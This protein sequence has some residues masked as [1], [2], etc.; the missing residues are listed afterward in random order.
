MKK[1]PLALSRNLQ[2]FFI[3]IFIALSC[4]GVLAQRAT[5]TPT[6]APGIRPIRPI[7]VKTPVLIGEQPPSVTVVMPADCKNYLGRAMQSLCESKESYDVCLSYL[8][9]GKWDFCALAG[10]EKM[11]ARR[12]TREEAEARLLK[13]NCTEAKLGRALI[14]Q[15]PSTDYNGSSANWECI[16]YQN[17]TPGIGCAPP[18]DLLGIYADKIMQALKGKPVGLAFVVTNKKG[19]TAERAWG[20]ARKSPDS[21]PMKMTTDSKYSL[22]SVSKNIT[23]AALMH[24][25]N[26]KGVKVTDR[27]A[28]YLP[29]DFLP[30]MHISFIGIT[31]EELLTHRAG[32]RCD[33]T[34]NVDYESLKKCTAIGVKIDDKSKDC[35]G[36]NLGNTTD[37]GCYQNT[38]Y[39]LMRLLIPGLNGFDGY[40]IKDPAE[41]AAKFAQLYSDYVNAVDF[42]KAGFKAYCHPTD[43]DKQP[44]AYK[45]SAPNGIGGDFGNN[46]L[47]CGSMGWVLSAKMLSKYFY[48]LNFS[49]DIVTKKVSEQ[50]RE[51]LYGYQAKS[52]FDSKFGKVRM[53]WHGGY[54][55]GSMN[56]GEINTIV[57][58]F[59]NGIQIAFIMNSDTPSSVNFGGVLTQS[60]IDAMNLQ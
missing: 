37:I 28:D 29:A 24:L 49:E 43:G 8:K 56:P 9:Q 38:D 19:E 32:I 52:E 40:K 44:L 2:I 34:L 30:G 7:L 25:L 11:V 41:K 50:M 4:I 3:T 12:S 58:N 27:M 45:L 54:H 16:A 5:P 48:K 20:V 18:L 36:N 10:S 39:A 33:K 60:M 57:I 53:Y 42:S 6:P 22:A 59:S 31:F 15:C 55:P 35:N 13:L 47:A 23:A 26:S 17:G 51:K 14:F 46:D 21:N 1:Q